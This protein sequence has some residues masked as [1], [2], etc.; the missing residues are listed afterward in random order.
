M[1][2]DLPSVTVTWHGSDGA[3]Q[4]LFYYYGCDMEETR[5]IADR[6]RG[7]PSQLPI[8]S[9]VRSALPQ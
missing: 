8:A 2:T 7:A 6:L 1:A 4:S 5:A 9:Y 3:E